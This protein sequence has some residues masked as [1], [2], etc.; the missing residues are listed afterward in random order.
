[1]A[2]LIRSAKSGSDWSQNELS[3]YNIAVVQQ[4][5]EAFFGQQHFPAP[6]QPSVV[7]FMTTELEDAQDTPDEESWKLL[8]YLTQAIDP[9]SHKAKVDV[10]AARLLEQLGYALDRRVI[11]YAAS[12]HAAQYLWREVYCTD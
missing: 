4:T 7:T 3:A 12:Y 11:I 6:A 8:F 10:F 2:H 9:D 1:M 5:K